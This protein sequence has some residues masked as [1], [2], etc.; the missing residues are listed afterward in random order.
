MPR[1]CVQ[2]ATLATAMY[3]ALPKFLADEGNDRRGEQIEMCVI[4]AAEIATDNPF[5]HPVAAV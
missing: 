1:N 2:I 5:V 4:S 3:I